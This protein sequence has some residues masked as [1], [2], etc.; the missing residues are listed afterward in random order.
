MV[1]RRFFTKSV[2]FFFFI[3]CELGFSSRLWTEGFLSFPRPVQKHPLL[4]AT[5]S[6][7]PGPPD[8]FLPPLTSIPS[9]YKGTLLLFP[10]R[11]YFMRRAFERVHVNSW[12]SSASDAI[13][14]FLLGLGDFCHP[15][16]GALLPNHLSWFFSCCRPPW[17][18][19]PSP[20]AQC[21]PR[22]SNLS[23]GLRVFLS[24][25]ANF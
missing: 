24:S 16:V 13:Y 10:K 3:E 11:L 18:F 21:K 7:R 23:F 5:P 20:V 25:F 1:L 2:R 4:P 15:G 19:P 22:F 12:G 14:P 8:L 17:V 6:E 9:M